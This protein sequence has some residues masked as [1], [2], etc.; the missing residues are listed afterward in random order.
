MAQLV[1]A[2]GDLLSQQ[3]A[4]KG[5]HKALSLDRVIV[6]SSP[7]NIFLLEAL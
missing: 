3:L 7:A 4:R 2:L 5:R 1:E 6:G